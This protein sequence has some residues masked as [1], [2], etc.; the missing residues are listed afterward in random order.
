M[1]LYQEAERVQWDEWAT[2]G[3]VKIHR[4]RPPRFVSRFPEKDVCAQDLHIE[5]KNAGLLDPVGNPLPV[6]AKAR[7]V[8]Q[9]QH[10]PD[11][12]QGLVRTD[13]PT[14]HRTAVSVFLQLVCR[15]LP[16]LRGKPREVEE[17]LFFEPPSRGLPIEI[18]KGVSGLPH[19]LRGWWKELRDTLQGESW[20]SLKLDPAFFCLRDCSE[21]LIGMIIV[22]VD[23][24]LFATNNTHQAESHIS[25]LLSKYDVKD[26]EGR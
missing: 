5:I 20:K 21:H 11:N 8:I 9:G 22:H 4:L 17:P 13:A 26:E 18:V 24:M 14:V 12:A 19:S 25:R 7:L 16:F 23:D 10:C 3:S 6:K 15:S 2:H 1:P